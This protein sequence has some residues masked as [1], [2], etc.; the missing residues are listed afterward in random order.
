MTSQFTTIIMTSKITANILDRY[1]GCVNLSNSHKKNLFLILPK[2][3][4]GR[5]NVNL[6]IFHTD[7]DHLSHQPYSNVRDYTS[8]TKYHYNGA[9]TDDTTVKY[10]RYPHKYTFQN[11][12]EVY[13][14]KSFDIISNELKKDKE[15][16]SWKT[17]NWRNVSSDHRKLVN[18]PWKYSFN[19]KESV[20][21]N[22][23]LS[24]IR[25]S[26]I[27]LSKY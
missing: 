2:K 15:D 21:P 9:Q 22:I 23:K 19:K 24:Q 11:K 26:C 13:G 25:K 7:I 20:Y 5:K 1:A 16:K 3:G 4:Y 12:P 10:R 27:D 14:T 18:E 6:A 17:E 8:W